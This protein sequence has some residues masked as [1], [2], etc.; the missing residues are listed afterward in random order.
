MRFRLSTEST[1]SRHTGLLG[2]TPG[3]DYSRKLRSFNQFA[4]PE[5]QAAIGWLSLNAGARVL[6]AGCGIGEALPWLA[7][8]AGNRGSVLGVDLSA[9]HV[10]AAKAFESPSIQVREADLSRI[11]LPAASFDLIWCVNT[12]NHF[13]RPVETV[14]R[15]LRLLKPHGRLAIGQSSLLPDMFFAWDARLE[16]LV[17]AAVRRYYLERYGLDERE[18]AAVRSLA[19]LL[20]AAGLSE[21][22]VQTRVIER[23]SPL[24]PATREYLLETIFLNTWGERLRP[25]LPAE[26]YAALVRLCD[27]SGGDFALDRQDFHFLQTFTLACGSP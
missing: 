10:A 7:E 26:D 13:H 6:D 21:V 2:D 22:S 9:A 15:L 25:F 17:D 5:L 4:A 11:E 16:R 3:R 20:R 12:I 14:R 23:I 1:A 8:A 27:P 19:G 24:D 18:L